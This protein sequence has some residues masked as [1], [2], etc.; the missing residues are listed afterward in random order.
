MDNGSADATVAHMAQHGQG[1]TRR[2]GQ[3][4]DVATHTGNAGRTDDARV[5][6]ALHAA[7]RSAYGAAVQVVEWR[8]TELTNRGG[9][10]VVRY[11]L[12][13]S[14]GVIDETRPVRWIGKFYESAETAARVAATL[15]GLEAAGYTARSGAVAPRIVYDDPGPRLLLATFEPGD[16]VIDRLDGDW[17]TIVPAV[18]RALAALHALPAPDWGNASPEEIVADLRRRVE[19]LCGWLPEEEYALRSTLARLEQHAATL[20]MPSA[21]THGDFGAGQLL[22]QRGRLVV[23]DFDKCGRGDPAL[24]LGN[25]TAQ[26]RRRALLDGLAAPVHEMRDLLLDVYLRAAGNARDRGDLAARVAWY[27]HVVLLRRVHFFARQGTEEWR[28]RALRLLNLLMRP[29]DD[30]D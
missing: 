26:L 7:A 16:P 11:D 5:A 9:R 12:T 22:W 14:D 29:P 27:E 13:L 1:G 23:L 28:E 19:A 18:A 10:R 2:R 25:F 15:R 20:P 8:A 24:D 6:A 4:R 30:T 17:P 3:R 21:L